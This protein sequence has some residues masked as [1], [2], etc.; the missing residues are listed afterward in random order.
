[1][2]PEGSQEPEVILP[3]P[4]CI[5]HEYLAH[6]EVDSMSQWRPGRGSLS[7]PGGYEFCTAESYPHLR[8]HCSSCRCRATRG[9]YRT[10]RVAQERAQYGMKSLGA[11]ARQQADTLDTLNGTLMQLAGAIGADICG[12][13]GQCV[14]CRLD[15][16]KPLV[17]TIMS[18]ARKATELSSQIETA[19]G[20]KSLGVS[21]AELTG[22]VS[23]YNS[24]DYGEHDLT[25][26]LERVRAMH[27]HA[28]QLLCD[29]STG[30]DPS[31]E[32]CKGYK[33][34]STCA[35]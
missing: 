11:T 15:K 22:D 30:I 19:R 21:L 25:A 14:V 34:C 2:G 6:S 31:H 7:P 33:G 3:L 9:K 32:L 20:I 10:A 26:E 35:V 13:G 29:P 1:M 5:S 17:D 28:M 18:S 4:V 23:Q 8:C 12:C 16:V 24:G 27:D